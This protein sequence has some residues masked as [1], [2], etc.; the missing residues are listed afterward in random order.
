MKHDYKHDIIKYQ[1]VGGV[2]WSEQR[3]VCVWGG[4]VSAF[5]TPFS[6]REPLGFRYAGAPR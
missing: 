5:A 4:C 2:P 1:M 6:L 3:Q